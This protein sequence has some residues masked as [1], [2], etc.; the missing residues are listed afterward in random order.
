MLLEWPDNPK[1]KHHGVE[2]LVIT[3]L[4]TDGRLPNGL[5]LSTSLH[6]PLESDLFIQWSTLLCPSSS[7]TV[8]PK[9]ISYVH[10]YLCVTYFFL[11]HV[12]GVSENVQLLIL[13]LSLLPL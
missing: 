7:S 10:S 8:L 12:D 11:F 9:Y 2:L 13:A 5:H 3:Y 4:K 1:H 6:I